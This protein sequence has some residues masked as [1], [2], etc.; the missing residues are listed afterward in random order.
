MPLLID[1]FPI[2]EVHYGDGEHIGYSFE[3]RPDPDLDPIKYVH[4]R[5]TEDL[6]LEQDITLAAF[7]SLPT[8]IIYGQ[9]CID[10]FNG[11]HTFYSVKD[12]GTAA[13]CMIGL[14][15]HGN[16]V[17]EVDYRRKSPVPYP[18]TPIR[19]RVVQDWRLA[20]N[21]PVP[22][23]EL[24]TY[25]LRL[26][27]QRDQFRLELLNPD[28]V[29]LDLMVEVHRG[30]PVCH[31]GING[32]DAVLHLAGRKD[33]VLVVP[34]AEFNAPEV[35]STERPYVCTRGLLFPV[36]PRWRSEDGAK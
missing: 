33:G 9:A 36:E 13:L 15:Q 3:A 23:Q 24:T 14:S 22:E 21:E 29:G 8:A 2:Y 30:L 7:D 28:G 25:R 17:T 27:D 10:H 16:G 19:N 20:E 32:D 1:E 18:N 6:T 11:P 5:I 12:V 26:D 34:D 4:T 35:T 31:V